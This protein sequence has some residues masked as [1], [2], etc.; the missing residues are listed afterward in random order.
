MSDDLD[1]RND[2][3]AKPA[4]PKAGDGKPAEAE[5]AGPEAEAAG[6]PEA[7]AAELAELKDRLLRTLADMENLRQRTRR[8]IDEARKY[9]VTGF[10][11][12]MLEIADNLRRALDSVPAAADQPGPVRNLLAGIEMTERALLAAFE[13]HKIRKVIPERGERFDHKLHQAM[14]EL[15]TD[16]QP[17]GTVAEVMTPGYVIADRLLRAAMVGVAKAPPPANRNEAPQ[18]AGAD[19]G[20]GGG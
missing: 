8:E 1:K 11:R 15:P 2:T 9:A 16:E 4:E 12:D 5:A 20:A 13:K 6:G 17:P 19:S 10:A 18:A 7:A 14:F 3:E